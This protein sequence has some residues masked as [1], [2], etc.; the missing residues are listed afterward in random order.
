MSGSC[1]RGRSGAANDRYFS[2]TLALAAAKVL[3]AGIPRATVA[4][5]QN[6]VRQICIYSRIW[7]RRLFAPVRGG[8]R[9]PRLAF[10]EKPDESRFSEILLYVL[11]VL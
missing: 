4:I 9:R 2:S 11:N 3:H 6:V 5:T 7:R 10:Y 1:S 8:E